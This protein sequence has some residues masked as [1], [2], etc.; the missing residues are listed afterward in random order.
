[1]IK[2]ISSMCICSIDGVMFRMPNHLTEKFELYINEHIDPGKFL[3]AIFAN[4]MIGAIDHADFR[5]ISNFPYFAYILKHF[6]PPECF[7]SYEKVKA[8]IECGK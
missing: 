8:W 7:G 5:S 1:M 4:D 2:M 6:A 3:T